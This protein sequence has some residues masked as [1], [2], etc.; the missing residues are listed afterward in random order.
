[1]TKK[2]VRGLALEFAKTLNPV[3]GR[4]LCDALIDM[5][6][7]YLE[8]LYVVHGVL[9]NMMRGGYCYALDVH[10]SGEPG[11][12]RASSPGDIMG[13]LKVIVARNQRTQPC[14]QQPLR[15]A[16]ESLAYAKYGFPVLEAWRAY[17]SLVGYEE[18]QGHEGR[19]TE[20]DY[21]AMHLIV[22]SY[23]QH[24]TPLEP[25]SV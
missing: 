2:K 11:E 9:L 13:P 22:G 19:P 25:G 3:C 18:L 14:S 23:L 15:E 12:L 4:I 6:E 7:E 17:T 20:P 24:I 8:T 1:M 10:L 16:F 5:G 21:W